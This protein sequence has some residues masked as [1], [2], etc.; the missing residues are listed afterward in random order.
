M[1]MDHQRLGKKR[2]DVVALQAAPVSKFFLTMMTD[3]NTRHGP[4]NYLERKMNY[5]HRRK[6]GLKIEI[7]IQSKRKLTNN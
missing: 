3:K 6:M 2:W 7:F 4:L 1:V 5:L